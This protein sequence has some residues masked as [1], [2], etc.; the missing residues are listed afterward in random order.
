[1]AEITG[2]KDK[3]I[4]INN[5]VTGDFLL[6]DTYQSKPRS[7]KLQTIIQELLILDELS[8]NAPSKNSNME[9]KGFIGMKRRGI[10]Q[11]GRNPLQSAHIKLNSEVKDKLSKDLNQAM[12]HKRTDTA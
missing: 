8:I 4:M 1:M 12:I 10:K 6:E 5:H 2:F 3:Q 9:E 11:I 7:I